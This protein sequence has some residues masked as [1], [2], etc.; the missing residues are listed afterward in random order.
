MEVFTSVYTHPE[1]NMLV[2]VNRELKKMDATS[3]QNV[4]SSVVIV[5]HLFLC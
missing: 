4:T 1:A 5:Q 2:P 3:D